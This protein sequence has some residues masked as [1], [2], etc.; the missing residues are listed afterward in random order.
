MRDYCISKNLD[1]T[2]QLINDEGYISFLT[3]NGIGN[4]EVRDGDKTGD[5]IFKARTSGTDSKHF[6]FP[7]PIKARNGIHITL[8]NVTAIIGFLG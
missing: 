3:I 7:F 4:I 5:I 1:S 6:T 2:T 8:E